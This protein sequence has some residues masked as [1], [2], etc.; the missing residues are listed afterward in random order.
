MGAGLKTMG[1]LTATFDLQQIVGELAD[2]RQH[3]AAA[4]DRAWWA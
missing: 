3:A 4:I 2:V 1:E